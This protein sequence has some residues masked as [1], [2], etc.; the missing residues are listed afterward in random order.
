MLLRPLALSSRRVRW[1]LTPI[2]FWRR[3]VGCRLRG[4]C[5]GTIPPALGDMSSLI[6]FD[7][8]Y[9][10]LLCGPLP[11]TLHVDW[12]WQWDHST[13]VARRPTDSLVQMGHRS[14]V[15][16]LP[17]LPAAKASLHA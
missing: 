15:L 5:A 7:A 1:S 11:K 3:T 14:R 6:S 4:G 10:P 2:R 17:G 8:R 13:N 12:D 9:N 16:S